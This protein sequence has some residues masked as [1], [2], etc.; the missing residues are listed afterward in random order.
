MTK[1]RF[2]IVRPEIDSDACGIG[3]DIN[4]ALVQGWQV[5]SF[6]P[7]PTYVV[8]LLSIDEPDPVPQAG[9]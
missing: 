9:K 2:F 5:S 6:Y 8:I 7:Q 1:H 4:S 3:S